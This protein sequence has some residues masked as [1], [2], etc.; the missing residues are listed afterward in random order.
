MSGARCWSVFTQRRWMSLCIKKRRRAVMT[1][2]LCQHHS[3][4]FMR[5][6]RQWFPTTGTE[7]IIGGIKFSAYSALVHWI[8][9]ICAKPL[10]R[11]VGA[12]T[13]LTGIHGKLT[14]IQ[15]RPLSGKRCDAADLPGRG[16]IGISVCQYP[17][18]GVRKIVGLLEALLR[19]FHQRG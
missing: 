4:F 7:P 5:A 12:L 6:S 2:L 15:R 18:Q 19:I 16:S 14:A 9:T 13:I 1:C 10:L 11:F 3:S 17:L 8:A